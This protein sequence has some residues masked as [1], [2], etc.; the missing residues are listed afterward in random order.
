MAGVEGQNE[1]DVSDSMRIMLAIQDMAS[2][3][4]ET[5]QQNHEPHQETQDDQIMRIQGEFR[6]T[7]PPVFKGDPN[8][9][10]AEEWLRQIKRK[11]NEQRVPGNLK[12]TIASTYLEGQAYHWWE[13]VLAMPDVEVATWVAF[14][15]MFLEKYFPE[16]MKT[17]K[18]REFTNLYQGGMTVGQYQAKF[19]ELMRFAP[20]IIPDE[21]A[22]AKKFEEGL[23]LEVKEK[24][25]LF[26]LKKYTEVVDRAL[27]AE[28]RIPSSKRIGHYRR[29][30]PQLQSYQ[31]PV[32]PQPQSQFRAPQQQFQAPQTQYRAPYQAPYQDSLNQFRGPVN[33]Q[34]QRPRGQPTQQRPRAPGTTRRS[35]QLTQGRVYVVGQ[36]TEPNEPTVVEGTFLVFNSWA[37]ILFDPGATNSFI[38]VSFA[39]IL[40][41][42]YEFMKSSLMIG[43][44]L[45]K[46]VEVNKLCKSCPIEISY[47]KLVV[48]LMILEFMVYDVIL[49]MDL[50]TQFKAILD[51]GRKMVTMTVN[52]GETFSF[53]GNKNS[54]KPE[55][56]L[57]NR[58]CNY[59]RLIAHMANKDLGDPKLELIPIVKNF[60]YIFPEDLSG[61]P[62]EREV[63]FPI[64]IYPGTSPISIP[65]HRMAPA[66]L[67]ELKIQLQELERK[68][69]IRPSTSPWGFPA[70]FVKKSDQ[71]LRMCIDYRQLNRVTIKNKYPLPRIDDLFDQLQGSRYFSKI[72][73]RSGYHQLRVKVEDVSKTAFR[74]R[75]GHYEFLVMPF[76]LTNTPAVFMDLVNQV[77]RPYLDQFVIV[78]IDDILIYYHLKKSMNNSCQLFY[79]H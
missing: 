62:P 71:S 49:G 78:F 46:C 17:M 18:V 44:P 61:L 74:T 4:R 72:D 52:E 76:G 38:S 33:Q 31:I 56:I 68:G 23:R 51:C 21:S 55:S 36:V 30:C 10:A 54:C 57:D 34:T 58:N 77:F 32:A 29:D 47:H 79:R 48:D 2:A 20:Y 75:Y 67:K 59:L 25:E 24:V 16:T 3:I 37:R 1:N 42:E 63:E 15:T 12:V 70:L 6:K 41:I 65:P 35:E 7:R 9:M 60:S 40:G 45:G 53:Y 28:Q 8:P 13:S 43:S 50:L 27:M 69:F 14:E 66:E 39:S 73:L 26:K 19:E 5:N 11:M 64:D 22:K